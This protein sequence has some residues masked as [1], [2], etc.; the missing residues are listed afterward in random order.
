MAELE[1]GQPGESFFKGRRIGHARVLELEI[2]NKFERGYRNREDITNLPPGILIVGSQNVLVNTSSRIQNRQGYKL[3]G[4][5]SSVDAPISSSFDWTVKGNGERHLRAGFLTSAGNN[6][7]LQFRYDNG[8]TVVWK[9]LLTSLSTVSYNFTT[10]WDDTE[11]LRLMLFVN[12]SGNIYE[13]NGAYDTVASITSNTITMANNI[14]ISGFYSGRD[15][16]I[17]IR[18]VT[19]TYS[20]ISGKTFTGVSPDPTAQGGNTPIAGDLAYQN[21]VTTASSSFTSGP[22]T[23]YNIDLISTLNNQV[24]IGSLTSPTFYLSNIGSY[25][26]YSFSTP[27]LP[28]EGGVATVDDNLIGFVPQEDVMYV[29]AGKDFWYNTSFVQST[30]FNLSGSFT[31]EIYQVKLLKVNTL[32]AAQSQALVNKMGNNIIMVTNEPAFELLGRVE[33]ILVT[34]QTSNLSDP[35]KIDFDDYDF[36]GGSVFSWR[37]FLFVAIPTESIVRMF[38]LTTKA[39]EAPQTI[40]ITRFYTVNGQLYGHSSTSSESYELFTGYSDRAIGSAPGQP[41]LVQASFSYQNFGSRTVQKN[42]NEFYIEGYINANT[43]LQCD[44]NYEVDG[45][46][47]TQT[48]SVNG[49]DKTIVCI[50]SDESSL[51]KVS[52]GKEKLGGDLSSSL[53]NLPPK[54]RVIKTFPRVNFYESQFA[55]SIFGADQRMEL[56]AFG[57]NSSPSDDTNFAIKQ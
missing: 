23:T 10:L 34:P 32:Q 38:N 28:G 14:G 46:M 19:Y 40:P 4:A 30:A 57:T 29:T 13:W 51:G 1:A 18:G 48:F 37:R 49:S 20:G 53:T 35:I 2:V 24:F 26:D 31:A 22:P 44:I 9:D 45:C 36:T 25:I 50:P 7:K 33:N 6:G 3:D 17:T 54:F 41:I 47:T 52:L 15:M 12:G 42:C 21:I 39:W 8:V 16:M 11:L 27:R 55:F 43:T 5:T 56:L